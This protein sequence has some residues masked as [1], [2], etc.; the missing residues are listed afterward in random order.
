MTSV[1][2]ADMMRPFVVICCFRTIRFNFKE[3]CHDLRASLVILVTVFFWI[4]YYT[5]FGFYLFRY[6]FEGS[7]KFL[8]LGMS[9]TS[10]YTALTTA[11]FPDVGLPAYQ[12]NFFTMF[13]FITFLLVGLYLLLNILL[14]IVFSKFT[15]RLEKRIHANRM[16]RRNQIVEIYEKFETNLAGYLNA[17]ECKKLIAFVYDFDMETRSGRSR[18]RKILSKMEL[19]ETDEVGKET[20]VNFLVTRGAQELRSKSQRHSIF[21]DPLLTT[22]RILSGKEDNVAS[23]DDEEDDAEDSE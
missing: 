17:D 3:F 22:S 13:F 1:F 20:I 6:S 10:L 12:R 18:Y 4:F 19:D 5:V 8:N 14:A 9:Y 15:M 16:K 21:A 11:N 2:V 7:T 23:D